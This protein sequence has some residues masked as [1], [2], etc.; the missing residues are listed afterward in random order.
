[1][2][3]KKSRA[4]K[5][6]KRSNYKAPTK[7]RRL[8]SRATPIRKNNVLTSGQTPGQTPGQR[9]N[10]FA[11]RN[12]LGQQPQRV[13]IKGRP[14]EKNYVPDDRKSAIKRTRTSCKQRPEANNQTKSKGQGKKVLT[15]DYVPWCKTR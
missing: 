3:R 2:A 11:Q 15:R 10:L 4:K 8:S 12:Q 5:S 7:V 6:I 13:E 9:V 14:V 1:M